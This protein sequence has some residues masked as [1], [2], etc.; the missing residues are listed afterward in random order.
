MD[1]LCPF[2]QRNDLVAGEHPGLVS[3]FPA[4]GAQ[5]LAAGVAEVHGVQLLQKQQREGMMGVGGEEEEERQVWSG[6]G[7]GKGQ[8]WL[9]GLIREG[10]LY[11]RLAT[12]AKVDCS[13]PGMLYCHASQV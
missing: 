5:R 11:G 13:G 8:M 2:A 1:L 3:L 4:L 9:L 12:A 6:K 7:A 10:V